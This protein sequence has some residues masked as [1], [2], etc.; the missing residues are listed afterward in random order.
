MRSSVM[1]AAGADGGGRFAAHRADPAGFRWV[2]YEWARETAGGRSTRAALLPGCARHFPETGWRIADPH[3]GRA[4]AS[5]APWI[6]PACSWVL[7]G[8]S[9]LLVGGIGVATRRARLARRP[10]AQHCHFALPWREESR[11]ILAVFLI[12][13][14]GL[15]AAGSCIGVGVAAVLPAASLAM[16]GDL[17]PLP[18]KI[19]IYPGPLA[20]AALYGLLTAAAF[21][22]WPLGR[23][24]RIP[25]AALFRD[26][27]R[28]WWA[29]QA[30]GCAWRMWHWRGCWWRRDRC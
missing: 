29:A 28:A 25:G 12:Q 17:L 14:L 9:A 13:V 7:V 20:L 6:R 21:A 8:L 2:T 4:G 18:A 16:F 10:G 15:C 24:A 27:F 26:A 23:A 1:G 19:G 5:A 11:L 3:A 30:R 22:L